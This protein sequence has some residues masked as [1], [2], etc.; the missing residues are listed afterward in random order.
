MTAYGPSR[1]IAVSRDLGRFRVEA[2]IKMRTRPSGPV[3]I[4]PD[5]KS[6]QI[7]ILRQL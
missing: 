1:H 3:A 4:D 7:C 5:R 2:D 6:D